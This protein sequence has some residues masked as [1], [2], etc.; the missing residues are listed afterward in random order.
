M[1]CPRLRRQ[2]RMARSAPA[3]ITAPAVRSLWPPRYLVA[4]W[5]TRS[6]RWSSGD[7]FTGLANVLSTT[8]AAPT[9]WASAAVAANVDD[10]GGR[11]WWAS[12]SRRARWAPP[13]H[14]PASR[15]RDAGGTSCGSPAGQVAGQESWGAPEDVPEADDVVARARQLGTNRGRLGR[16]PRREG[17]RGLAALDVCASFSRA[18]RLGRGRTAC[19][20]C[21]PPCSF[22]MMSRRSRL[23]RSRRS[24]R[25]RRAR[26]APPRGRAAHRTD[27]P[28]AHAESP[29]LWHRVAPFAEEDPDSGGGTRTPDTRIMIPRVVFCSA[30][31]TVSREPTS[32]P[33]SRSRTVR[34]R[35][36][37]LRLLQL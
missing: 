18:R 28:G 19:R 20:G 4:L 26:A 27:V 21:P 16:H 25:C 10:L 24:S 34:R 7:W 3:P 1:I 14:A 9:A 37:L 15:N 2:P 35:R 11:G 5:M 30:A 29:E 13:A 36:E 23:T 8:T 12:R 17:Q 33:T 32:W 31:H 6:A 22:H